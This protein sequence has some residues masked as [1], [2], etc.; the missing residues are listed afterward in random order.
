MSEGFENEIE[1]VEIEDGEMDSVVPE[2]MKRVDVCV[3]W[4]SRASKFFDISEDV[5][6]EELETQIRYHD[7]PHFDRGDVHDLPEYVVESIEEVN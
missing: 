5:S 3:S 7:N 1:F 2:G 4:T 6:L